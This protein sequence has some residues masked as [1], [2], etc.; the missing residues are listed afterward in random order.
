MIVARGMLKRSPFSG[1][2]AGM[3]MLLGDVGILH[4]GVGAGLF[5]FGVLNILD[6]QPRLP[7]S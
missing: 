6:L 4:T 7:Q 2:G 3:T 1:L 5:A